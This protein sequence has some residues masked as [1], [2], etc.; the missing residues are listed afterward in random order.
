MEISDGASASVSGRIELTKKDNVIVVSNATLQVGENLYIGRIISNVEDGDI[1]G[2][3]FEIYGS[4]STV[5]VSGEFK[6]YRDSVLQINLPET[7]Y[8]GNLAPV[9]VGTFVINSTATL[10]IEGISEMRQCGERDKSRIPLVCSDSGVTIPAGI[11]ESVNASFV[12][13]G[14]ADCCIYVSD[15]GKNLMLKVPFRKGSVFIVR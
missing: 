1:S 4:N 15:D 10:D 12:S 3:R 8:V 5:S 9:R 11:I 7:G 6:L 14:A 2:N 13:A